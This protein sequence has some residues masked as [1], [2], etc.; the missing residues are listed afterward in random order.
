MYKF[1][2]LVKEGNYIEPNNISLNSYIHQWMDV[3]VKPYNSP[4]TNAG[5]MQKI[6]SYICGEKGGIGHIAV[7][8]LNPMIIQNFINKIKDKSPVSG[9]PL[10]AKTVRDTYII[11][12]ACLNNAVKM[13]IINENPAVDIRLPKR[14][15]KE[16]KVFSMEEIDIL[17]NHLKD[18]KSDME[19]PV[20]LALSMG[21]RRGE[22][23]GLRF[24]DVD[25]EKKTIAIHNN[26]VR[27]C[28]YEIVEKA[29]KT[30]NSIRIVNVP[31]TILRMIKRQETRW[32]KKQLRYGRDYNKNG[33]ICYKVETGNPW[34]PD[35]LTQ[36]Y[37]RM[38]K[39]LGLTPVSFHG[40]RHCFASICLHQNIELL[41]IS[42][43]LGHS[44]ASFTLDT[45]THLLEDKGSVV[46]NVM[47]GVLYKK[48][49]KV[50]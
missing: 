39:N 2:K 18:T 7:Q 46:A 8:K 34:K 9:N 11:L 12:K 1:E 13:K 28:N 43:L 3:F 32:K 26:R 45:Y 23:L 20:N 16:I 19:L 49:S 15:K 40:L 48:S 4:T 22:V 38:I 14:Q 27:R 5:Y 30:I 47:D 37:R 31:D 17:L 10:S 6:D 33:Y 25:Y 44:S 21:L 42:K 24:S 35:N 41:E 36:K 29:P 50:G